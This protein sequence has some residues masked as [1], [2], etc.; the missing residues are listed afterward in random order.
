MQCRNYYFFTCTKGIIGSSFKENGAYG[1]TE[2]SAT[3]RNK[4]GKLNLGG[5]LL[6]S[7]MRKCKLKLLSL[8]G[9]ECT[10]I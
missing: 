6:P 8:K 10:K 7:L 4:Q 2:L 3:L 5:I 1:L 9:M